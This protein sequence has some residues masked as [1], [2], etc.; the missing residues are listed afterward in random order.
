MPHKARAVQ[1][2]DAHYDCT[3]SYF[4]RAVLYGHQFL[5]QPLTATIKYHRNQI[6]Q[7]LTTVKAVITGPHAAA[8][9]QAS[10]EEVREGFRDLLTHFPALKLP[11]TFQA[12][13]LS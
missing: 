1:K 2:L 10:E 12:Q 9:E 5:Q 3:R 8:L 6:L 11:T 13:P 7:I 4:K